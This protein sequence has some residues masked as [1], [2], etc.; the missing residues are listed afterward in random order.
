[1]SLSGQ[2]IL[3][4]RSRMKYTGIRESQ[5]NTARIFRQERVYTKEQ[6]SAVL[7][8]LDKR[9]KTA[10]REAAKREA[11]AEARETARLAAEAAK[12]AAAEKAREV[13]REAAR[14]ARNAAARAARAAKA[15]KEAALIAETSPGV[16]LT[17]RVTKDTDPYEIMG[18]LEPLMSH[19]EVR[20]LFNVDGEN[21]LDEILELTK[22]TSREALFWN[23]IFRAVLK[24]EGGSQGE[25]IWHDLANK[26]GVLVFTTNKEVAAARMAQRFRDG[27]VHC[28][29]DPLVALYKKMGENSDSDASR[30]RCFQIMRKIDSLRIKYAD[31]V[32]ESDMEEVA[33]IAC[34]RIVITDMFGKEFLEYNKKSPKTFAW[35]NTR[36]HHVDVG[37]LAVSGLA[38]KVS[39][40]EFDVIYDKHLAAYKQNREV[41]LMEGGKDGVRCIRSANGAWRVRDEMF[42][43]F[44]EKS[45]KLGINEYGLNAVKYSEVNEYIRE[46]CVVSAAPVRL[47]DGKATGHRD[48]ESAYTQHQMTSYYQGFLGKIQQG[49]RLNISNAEARAFLVDHLGIFRCRILSCDNELL[50]KLGLSETVTLPSPEILYFIDHGVQVQIISGVFGST[51]SATQDEMY[52]G[53]MKPIGE[54]RRPYTHYAGCFGHESVNKTFKFHGSKDWAGHL[55]ASGY[56]TY[57]KDGM[58]SVT[59]PKD[60]YYSHHHIFAFITSYTRINMLEAM[61]KFPIENLCAVVL[62]GIYFKGDCPDI[63][64]KFRNK[65]IK[66]ISGFAQG[67]YMPSIVPDEFPML[68]DTK[69]LGNCILSG[70][71]GCGK[72]YSVLTDLGFNDVLYVVPQHT[73]GIENARAHSVKYTTI[74]KLIG[75]ESF[76]KTKGKTVK[77][78]PWKDEH[79]MPAVCLI[80]EMTMIDGAWIEKALEMYPETLFFIAGDVIRHN[81]KMI[82]FQCRSGRP[83]QFNKVFDS[84]LPIK[85]FDVDRRS[86]DAGLREMKQEIRAKML[87]F[88]TDGEVADARVMTGWIRHRYGVKMDNVFA[89]GD[90]VIAGTHKTNETM[91]AGGV[92]SGYLSFRNERSKEAV[93]GWTRRGSFTTHSYQGSTITDGKVYVVINDAFELAMIYTAVSRAVSIDQIIFIQA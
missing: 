44:E 92:V 52:S 55:A 5:Y 12:E 93:E 82:A 2:I 16:L 73:L 22:K 36:E 20:I 25:S 4:D 54:T 81:G 41:F 84:G 91:L 15:A 65:P 85:Y 48:L 51:W 6:Y 46:A 32:P 88:Y 80:D 59:I 27:A 87:E 79:T 45:K 66:A 40:E 57:H 58:I 61:S 17:F 53:L 28:V 37:H 38:E 31:G 83:G 78:R 64:S 43:A 11:A 26:E 75:V 56:K 14:I 10:R 72:T 23:H 33:R 69:L 13:K 47:G 21:K 24:E 18:K 8:D 71:G 76:D 1:M 3:S 68:E 35:T 39:Q 29:I 30:K 63:D 9:E 86:R 90:T 19:N 74:H 60:F 7:K 42:D 67:W 49:R 62:D 89:A 70:Q 50:T 34:R 77:C